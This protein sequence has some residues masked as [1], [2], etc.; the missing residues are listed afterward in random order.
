MTSLDEGVLTHE[1]FCENINVTYC[2][3]GL[4]LI[5]EQG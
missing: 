4:M 2:L 3:A 5:E 1:Y